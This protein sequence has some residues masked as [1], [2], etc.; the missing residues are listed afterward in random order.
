MSSAVGGRRSEPVAATF[1]DT[2]SFESKS[3][4]QVRPNLS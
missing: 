2:M 1:R 3:K 4:D